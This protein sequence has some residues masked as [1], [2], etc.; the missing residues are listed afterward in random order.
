[1]NHPD[2]GFAFG[3]ALSTAVGIRPFLTLAITA[4][5]M[6]SGSLNPDPHFAWLG[7]GG[8][9][10]IIWLLAA[11]E[12]VADKIPIVDHVFHI[13]HFASKPIVAALVAGGTI[14]FNN[15]SDMNDAKLGL[16]MCAAAANAFGLNVVA[17]TVRGMTTSL[18]FGSVN[19]I[20]SV[21]EDI[22]C[23]VAILVAIF[24]PVLGA[25]IAVVTTVLT[26]LLLRLCVRRLRRTRA[27]LAALRSE[28][29]GPL[30]LFFVSVVIARL[31]SRGRRRIES[32]LASR[33]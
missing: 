19:P 20:V 9:A 30:H 11:M 23:V 21:L 1:V 4:S 24:V 16:E 29:P 7:H 14:H 27:R 31:S 32:A 18:T 26:F 13:F 5:M 8:V 3:L 17:A 28:F 10:I 12:F 6:W 15:E 22:V 33:A 25:A 2:G